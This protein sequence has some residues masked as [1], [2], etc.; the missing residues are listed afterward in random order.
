MSQ[1][2][3]PERKPTEL[4]VFLGKW[5]A[6]GTSFGGTDQSGDDPKANGEPWNSEHD[7]YWYT[8]EFFLVE[9]EKARPGGKIFD[10]LSIKGFDP[11]TGNFFARTFENHGHYRN[12]ALTR[13]GDVWKLTG[14]TERATITF[15]DGNRKQSH[16]W[17]WKPSG[18]WLP[19]C[20]R[21]AVRV[22]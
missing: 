12:Y 2:T 6:E 5:R 1:S 9:D 15:S 4:D 3:A 11:E 20:D 21:T 19:L 16:V 7:G 10:T 18:E 17:E 8:G 13:E 22:D 14:D